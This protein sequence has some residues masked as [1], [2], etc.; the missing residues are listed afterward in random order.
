[1]TSVMGGPVFISRGHFFGAD[2]E[3]AE[4]VKFVD[5]NQK[6]ITADPERDNLFIQIERYSGCNTYVNVNLQI[7]LLQ[8]KN[9]LFE[10]LIKTSD[11]SQ[12][13]VPLF[14]MRVKSK[15]GKE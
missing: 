6:E 10:P 14:N 13:F 11:D 9:E 8:E 12:S 15:F 3:V 4:K 2:K 7:N 5:A 1:M